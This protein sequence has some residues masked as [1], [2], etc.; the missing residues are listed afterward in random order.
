MN[1][2][3]K[4]IELRAAKLAEIEADKEARK[5]IT[6][7]VEARGDADLT[8]EESVDYRAKTSAIAEKQDVVDDLSEQIRELE[9]EEERAGR[10]NAEVQA[11]LKSTTRTEVKEGLTYQKRNGFSYGKDLAAAAMGGVAGE[12]ARE[13]LRRHA[14]DVETNKEIR[15][16]I[17]TTDGTGGEFVPPLWVIQD[18]VKFARAARP[19]A[20]LVRSRPLPPGTDVI[21]VPKVATGTDVDVQATQNTTVHESSFTTTSVSADVVTIAGFQPVSRQQLDWS[22][23]R[24]DEE[25]FEDLLRAYAAKVDNQ[26]IGGAGIGSGQLLGVR[27]TPDIIT[28]T[29]T[30]AG[31]QLE[32]AQVLYRALADAIARIQTQAVEE[33]EVI[34]MAPRRW[35]ALR[36]A[37]NSDGSPAFGGSGDGFNR[38]AIGESTGFDRVVGELHNLPVV[39]ASHMP[40]TLGAGTNEDVVH[41]LRPTDLRLYESGPRVEAF[42]ETEAT[43]LQVILQVHGYSAFTAGRQPKSVV[44]IGGTALTAPTYAA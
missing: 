24:F 14:I 20:N 13:R 39:L 38:L 2:L 17:N 40:L 34:V 43:K 28:V 25:I 16:A 7:A 4:L 30:S 35:A 41:V 37:I 11:V 5:A 44:E 9:K 31:T 3:Q 36:A 21:K 12:E 29:A 32:K 23:I 8:E 33:P 26:V 1:R 18:Y 27:N 15:A 42:R 6:D 10:H 22:P 19:Y